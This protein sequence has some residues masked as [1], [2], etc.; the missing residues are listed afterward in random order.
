MS[1]LKFEGALELE[2][3]I[4]VAMSQLPAYQEVKTTLDRVIELLGLDSAAELATL[5]G[6]SASNLSLRQ[7][8][9]SM[10]FEWIIRIHLFT[11]IP[12]PKLFFGIDSPASLHLAKDP[13]VVPNLKNEVSIV[14]HQHDKLMMKV[15]DILGESELD[16]HEKLEALQKEFKEAGLIK[17]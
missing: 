3:K 15:T 2:R 4:G 7:T 9:N 6:V 16:P 5:L 1:D 12:M 10:P 13:L 11:G 17:R 8:R 14:E